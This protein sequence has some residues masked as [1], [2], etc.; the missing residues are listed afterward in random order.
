MKKIGCLVEWVLGFSVPKLAEEV[1]GLAV[2]S[3]GLLRLKATFFV[4][5]SPL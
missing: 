5:G 1:S 2:A 3:I 4:C